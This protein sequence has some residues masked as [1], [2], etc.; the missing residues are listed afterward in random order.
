MLRSLAVR[1]RF[2]QLLDDL[3]ARGT[4]G[5]SRII[6]IVL[7]A[8]PATLDNGEMTPKS[9]ISAAAVLRRRTATLSELFAD[10]PGPDVICAAEA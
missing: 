5:A 6:R 8:E 7:V 4:G 2:Q 9:A 10:A 3:A 1:A